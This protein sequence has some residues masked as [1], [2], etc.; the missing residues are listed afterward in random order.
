MR[1]H[2][3]IRWICMLCIMIIVMFLGANNSYAAT[4]VTIT[5]GQSQVAVGD[6]VSVKITVPDNAEV[7]TYLVSYSQEYLTLSSGTLDPLGFAGENSRTNTLIFT[8]TKVGTAKVSVAGEGSIVIN[9]EARNISG[10]VSINVVAV[11]KPVPTQTPT[12][13]SGSSGNSGSSGGSGNS[14]TT[15]PTPTPDTR[16]SNCSLASLTLSDG[17]LSPAFDS[18]ITEY[19]VNLNAKTTSINVSATPSDTKATI[20]GTG[21]IAVQ[22]GENKISIEVTAENGSKKTY[23]ITANVDEAPLVYTKLEDKSL[24]VVRSL[25]DVTIPEG[26]T[27]TT[28]TLEGQEVKAW[29]NETTGI[30]LVYLVDEEENAAFYVCSPDKGV[31]CKYAS[32]QYNGQNYIFA[33]IDE[34]IREQEGLTYGKVEAFGNVMD[35]FTFNDESLSSFVVLYLM[36][37]NNEY[38]YY[39][40]DTVNQTLQLFSG[41]VFS[42]KQ[43]AAM[44]SEKQV[45]EQKLN[46]E[47]LIRNISIGIAVV[48]AAGI[49]ELMYKLNTESKRLRRLRRRGESVNIDA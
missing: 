18:S 42:V 34:S 2:K 10:S 35:G 44:E 36:N 26:Y 23:T 20:T 5:A 1:G 38:G 45:L 48:L 3:K 28:T 47:I 39:T 19:S 11:S 25:R 49:V 31:I 33:G 30:T 13:P 29:T 21:D 9:G 41:A 22:P 24:G 12:K 7:W 15:K 16:S 6:T 4:N 17:T 37:G 8:A 40:Y 46:M 43:A 14:G 32:F 27:E